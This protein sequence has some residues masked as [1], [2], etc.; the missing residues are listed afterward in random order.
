M[1]PLLFHLEADFQLVCSHILSQGQDL[2]FTLPLPHKVTQVSRIVDLN[3][4]QVMGSMG[5]WHFSPHLWVKDF[6]PFPSYLETVSLHFFQS[7]L[8]H[9]WAFSSSSSPSPLPQ[10]PCLHRKTSP[11]LVPY[12]HQ[13][14]FLIWTCVSSFFE[15]LFLGA[16]RWCHQDWYQEQ[17]VREVY[18]K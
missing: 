5:C 17:W 13:Q 1:C 4:L 18:R 14:T 16:R 3:Y 12:T 15:S 7:S 6:F 8:I 9:H 2:Y 10:S 11:K